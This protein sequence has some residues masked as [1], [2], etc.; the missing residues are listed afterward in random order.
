[1]LA[2]LNYTPISKC[3]MAKLVAKGWTL[4]E[5]FYDEIELCDYKCRYHSRVN[6]QYTVG[7][8]YVMF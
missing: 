1:M 5:M 3:C 6:G 4:K 2:L 7:E 8:V